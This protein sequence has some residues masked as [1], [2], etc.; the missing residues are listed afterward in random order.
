M[1]LKRIRYILT[2]MLLGMVLINLLWWLSA[3]LLQL[4]ALVDPCKVYAHLGEVWRQSMSSHLLASLRRIVIG[5]GL[6]T[7]IGML[8]A[9]W[10]VR[11]RLAARLLGAFVYFAYPI[12]KLA[13]LPVVMLLAGL[14][15][16]PKIL[17][18]ILIIVFQIII[19]L[20]DSLRDIPK[21]SFLIVTSLGATPWQRLRYVV[22]P[23]VLPDLLSTLRVAIGT[24][25]SV[26][27]VTETYGT[28]RGMGFFIVDASARFN[29]TEMYA[30]IV[31]LSMLGFLLFLTT[32]LLEAWL[33]SWKSGQRAS[34]ENI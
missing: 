28:D 10:M 7:L 25:I 11:S 14:G 32:D 16:A 5:V 22:F 3:R 1:E 20:R 19:N 21:E 27:F 34:E 8:T 15:D 17:M 30:G 24:A 13:L 18:I 23:A 12:P 29:Y 31:I 26:L 2:N 9:F 33:C 6:A 4:P